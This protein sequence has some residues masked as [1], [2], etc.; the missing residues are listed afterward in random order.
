MEHD[1]LTS[2]GTH[3]KRM[4]H[5]THTFED[6]GQSSLFLFSSK[7]NAFCRVIPNDGTAKD[8]DVNN[9]FGVIKCGTNNLPLTQ[10][11]QIDRLET[12]LTKNPTKFGDKYSF[13]ITNRFNDKKNVTKN[14]DKLVN[15]SHGLMHRNHQR[16]SL[17]TL[18]TEN[19]M[20]V[21]HEVTC[22][23]PAHCTVSEKGGAFHLIKRK[24]VPDEYS[25]NVTGMFGMTRKCFVED[26]GEFACN[27]HKD[28]RNP[29]GCE[30]DE[31][32]D[33]FFKIFEATVVDD[34]KG[35]SK[36]KLVPWL[37]NN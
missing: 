37:H 13:H 8:D 7:N 2:P 10:S 20:I 5:L 3:A 31:K 4:H 22:N 23:M 16:C 35:S 28:C 1:E 15:L 30:P 19:K 33:T 12:L 25:I 29:F 32:K 18:H 14:G 24:D 6:N 26:T 17:K 34:D 21:Q 9:R 36:V 11:E 27:R